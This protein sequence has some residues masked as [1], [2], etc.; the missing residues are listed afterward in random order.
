MRGLGETQ[1]AVI[2]GD[3]RCAYLAQLLQQA[4]ASVVTAA[5][6]ADG[7]KRV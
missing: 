1:L 4:G 3:R 6:D 2:G 5:L 7:V